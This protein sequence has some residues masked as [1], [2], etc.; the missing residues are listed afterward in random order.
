MKDIEVFLGFAN[1]Y[2]RFIQNFSKIAGSLTSM[3]RASPTRSAKNLLLL[4]N[5]AEDAEVGV[6]GGDREDK[7]VGRSPSKNS[8]KATGYLTPDARQAFTQLRQAFTKAPILRH[9]DPKCHIRIETNA[10][11][12]AIAELAYRLGPMA[13]DGLLFAKN[14]SGQ[15]SIRNLRR[16]AFGHCQSI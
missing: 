3:L 10:S 8:N 9:F 1:F 15:D 7:M 2:Q 6:D 14:D 11:G 16:W 12:Y 5:M 4:V 13:P